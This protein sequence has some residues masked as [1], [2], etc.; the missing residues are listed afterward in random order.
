MMGSRQLV[1]LYSVIILSNKCRSGSP[2]IHLY[3][4]PLGCHVFDDRVVE[5]FGC[6]FGPVDK[7]LS[8]PGILPG[9]I[10]RV[11][12]QSRVIA[13]ILHSLS[14]LLWVNRFIT[15]LRVLTSVCDVIGPA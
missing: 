10:S 4:Y 6:G 8:W 2:P 9:T 12:C 1:W 3:W 14:C 5:L 11:T 7:I 13:H 15:F